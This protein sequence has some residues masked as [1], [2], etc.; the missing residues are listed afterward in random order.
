[1]SAKQ[2]RVPRLQGARGWQARDTALPPVMGR[3]SAVSGGDQP[4]PHFPSI[5]SVVRSQALTPLSSVEATRGQEAV[6]ERLAA[7]G[8]RV[9]AEGGGPS[10]PGK[11]QGRRHALQTIWLRRRPKVAAACGASSEQR[12][13]PSAGRTCQQGLPLLARNRA[14][15]QSSGGQAGSLPGGRWGCQRAAGAGAHSLGRGGASGRRAE[16]AVS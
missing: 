15:P 12:E 9:G 4:C 1:M 16:R 3:V 10:A 6:E 2:A 5:R 8:G 7:S 14:R 13:E 11:R